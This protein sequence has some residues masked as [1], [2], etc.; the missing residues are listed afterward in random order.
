MDVIRDFRRLAVTILVVALA[1][2][3]SASAQGT[4]AGIFVDTPDGPQEVAVYVNRVAG[5]RLRPGVGTLDEVH[6][7]S[8]VIRLLCNLPFWRMRAAWLSTGRVLRDDRA[9]RRVLR[10]RSR[11]TSLTTTFVQIAATENPAELRKLLDQVGASP[12]NPA[13]VFVTMESGGMLRDYIVGIDA[14][15]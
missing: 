13:Y 5:G 3:S 10:F 12:E 7:V 6:R 2:P 15:P 4:P 1:V 14:D 9:E 8:G 11:R